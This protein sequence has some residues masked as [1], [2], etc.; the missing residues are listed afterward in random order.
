[1][2]ELEAVAS[3]LRAAGAEGSVGRPARGNEPFVTVSR[4]AGSGGTRLARLLLAELERRGDPRLRG[5]RLYGRELCEAL[6]RDERLSVD[7]DALLREAYRGEVEDALARVI[8]DLSPQ[9]AVL[10]R[11]FKVI[12]AAAAAG[13]AVIVGRG[14]SCATARLPLGVHVRLVAPRRTR[15]AAFMHGTRL[16][17][18][19][20]ERRLDEL[21]RSRAALVKKQFGRDIDD[22]LLYDATY[23][24][25][26]VPLERVA[27]EVADL[28]VLRVEQS[29]VTL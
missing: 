10:G 5:W 9:S 19:D 27:R 3:L 25:D 14:A 13:R 6:A 22:P 11:L 29:A 7:L 1:M 23:N 26:R 28:V 12:R 24:V 4:Q 15:L 2:D 17:K 20:A 8:G 16:G 18:E 21:D